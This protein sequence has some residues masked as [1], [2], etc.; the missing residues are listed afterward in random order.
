MIKTEVDCQPPNQLHGPYED[1][2]SKHHLSLHHCL[3]NLLRDSNQKH[4]PR[5]F[6]RRIVKMYESV[7][8]TQAI[9]PNTSP[10]S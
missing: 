5:L 3:R 1:G 10:R 2:P 6:T 7:A 9:E 4:A 8:L